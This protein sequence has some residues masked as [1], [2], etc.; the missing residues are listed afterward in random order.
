MP[1]SSVAVLAV[2]IGLSTIT[3]LVIT[4]SGIPDIVVT[5]AASFVP[6]PVSRLFVLFVAPGGGDRRPGSSAAWSAGSSEPLAVHALD[7]RR[8]GS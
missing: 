8:A 6:L 4:A 2:T 5:L 1:G 3:G 7:P